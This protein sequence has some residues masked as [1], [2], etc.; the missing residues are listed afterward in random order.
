MYW[1][2]KT[3]GAKGVAKIIPAS[4]GDLKQCME[5]LKCIEKYAILTQKKVDPRK[6][7]HIKLVKRE[8]SN[9]VK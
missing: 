2:H 9:F 4:E 8:V 3:M 5:W 1:M 7:L 6:I